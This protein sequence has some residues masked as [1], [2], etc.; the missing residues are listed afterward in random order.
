[1][2]ENMTAI[3]AGKKLK[4]DKK[5]MRKVH[6]LRAAQRCLFFM[7]IKKNRITF[8]LTERKGFQC[9]AK[10][11]AQELI[12]RYGDRVELIWVTKYPE[13]CEKQGALGIKV[14]AANS[15]EHWKYQLTSGVVIVNDAFHESVVLRR[16][17]LKIN[18]WHACMNYKKI[19]K[20]VI[21]FENEEQVKLFDI[22]NKQ[23][24]IYLSGSEFF[25][26]DT[27]KSFGFDK[28]RFIAT[29]LPRND[30]LFSDSK[31]LSERIK[32]MYGISK[33]KRLVLYAPTFRKGNV[34]SKLLPD[35][36]YLKSALE[37]RFS[38]Q[39]C[40]LYR[41]HQ[42]V[43]EKEELPSGVIDVSDY[44]DMNELLAVSDVLISDYSSCLWD[45]SLTY[46][47]SFVFAPDIDKYESEDRAFA[48]PLSKW[49]YPIAG[50]ND[51]LISNISEFDEQ[52]YR[53][54]ITE[55]HNTCKSYDDGN[56]TKRVVDIIAREIGI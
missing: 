51:E 35:F 9:S 20:A 13:T 32:S 4:D 52:A 38:G 41:N 29:G 18:T 42:F 28:S 24:D 2:K 25:T 50:S 56:A 54:K 46:R 27:S 26:E 8:Y 5:Y 6:I 19:G 47:P 33:E 40:V 3:D 45:F 11:I 34:S 37:K 39:W 49:P 14:V 7:P 10:Y 12:K 55:H 30:I 15:P 22:R 16:G 1:M 21:P 31:N 17:Q 23:P 36:E 48:F 53:E 44:D 43:S